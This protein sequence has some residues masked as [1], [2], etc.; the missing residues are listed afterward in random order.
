MK[1]FSRMLALILAMMV[2]L[3]ACDSQQ[4]PE[5]QSSQSQPQTSQT[6]PQPVERV[7]LPFFPDDTLNPYTC[8]TLQNSCLTSLL[9]DPLVAL[10]Q[11]YEPQYRLAQEVT[12]SGV[13]CVI[14]LRSGL[15]FSGGSPVTAEDVLS[16]L[17]L[18]RQTP[19]F[20]AGLTGVVAAEAPDDSTVVVTLSQ[21]DLYFPR[22]LTFPILR[23]GTET[24][25]QP[26]GCGR[27]MME[28]GQTRMV[29]NGGY[30]REAGNI[31]TVELVATQTME[32]QSY[33][34]M[35]GTIDLMYSD[36]QSDLNLGLGI[37]YRQIPLSNMVYLGVN[38]Q[39]LGWNAQTR[40]AFSSMVD[41]EEITRKAYMGFAAATS[42][43]I[44]PAAATTALGVAQ[45]ELNVDRQNRELD[46]L[47]WDQRDSE[48][49]RTYNGRRI[50]VGL[51]VNSENNTREAVAQLI[52]DSCAQLGVEVIVESLPFEQ[53]QE[54]IASGQYDLYLGEVKLPCNLDLSRLIFPDAQLGPGAEEDEELRQAHD[55]FHSGALS[56]E[57]FETVLSEKMPL[58]PLLFRRGIFCFS[59][60]FSVNI[61]AT[62]QD[63]FYNIE[64]W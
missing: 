63:I 11:D 34:V 12:V 43:P 53:F 1:K 35:E 57:E 3:T 47:G 21:Q 13:S 18:A 38:S 59:R 28:E 33:G 20:S 48:G 9:Y 29:V 6:S 19:R 8:Q 30:Y 52:K 41:R 5:E 46:G 54:R 56:Q 37:G 39:R 60:D 10:D 55:Q 36:L 50:S 49:W 31:R 42:L 15:T 23:S 2:I 22:S 61:V 25:Q 16:S 17:E 32:E 24:Q 7:R 27:F 58:I 51:L 14:K 26:I 44:N 64:E 4:A 45:L 62:E 40:L